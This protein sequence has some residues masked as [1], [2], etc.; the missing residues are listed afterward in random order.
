MVRYSLPLLLLLASPSLLANGHTGTA[1]PRT[2]PELSDLALF[3][4]AAAG[5]WFTR[6]ALR[7]R[8]RKD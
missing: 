1:T 4:M 8:A 5:I 3:A 6:R 2:A 7:N